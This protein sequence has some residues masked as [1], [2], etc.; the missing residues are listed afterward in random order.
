[1]C[2]VFLCSR[3]ACLS[4]LPITSTTYVSIPLCTLHPSTLLF[5]PPSW[6]YSSLPL[7]WD[8]PHHPFKSCIPPSVHA[9]HLLTYCVPQHVASDCL[10]ISSHSLLTLGGRLLHAWHGSKLSK[11]THTLSILLTTY[12]VDMT[13]PSLFY[14]RET[15]A[16]STEP[17][18]HPG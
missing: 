17:V 9:P 1:M 12:E 4:S 2:H 7:D 8:I 6:S 11:H 14:R 18:S 15:E 5:T 3:V 10:P 13:T 16:Q